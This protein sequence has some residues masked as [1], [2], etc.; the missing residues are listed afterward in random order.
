MVY[1]VECMSSRYWNVLLITQSRSS[2]EPSLGRDEETIP[3]LEADVTSDLRAVISIASD[4]ELVGVPTVVA[5]H[6]TRTG[7]PVSVTAKISFATIFIAEIMSEHVSRCTI[8]NRAH[9]CRDTSR[10]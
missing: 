1:K 10:I 3:T 9:Q 8:S 7:D 4:P 5:L 2:L 6:I